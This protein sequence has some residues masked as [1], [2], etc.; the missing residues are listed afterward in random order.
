MG[1][2]LQ[3]TIETIKDTVLTPGQGQSTDYSPGEL[4]TLVAGT[5]LDVLATDDSQWRGTKKVKVTFANGLTPDGGGPAKNTWW[6]YAPGDASLWRIV[7]NNGLPSLEESEKGPIIQIPGVGPVGL[8]DPIIA[9]GHFTW[10]EATMGGSRIPQ[11]THIPG[12]I[13]LPD[14]DISYQ[15]I[16]LAQ[17]LE[18]L[19]G[20]FGPLRINSW[21]RDPSSNKAVGGVSNSRHLYGHAADVFPLQ[22]DLR[23]FQ[24]WC[25][26]N[27]YGG[28]GYTY[29]WGCHLDLRGYQ[30]RW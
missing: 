7:Y 23:A 6:A 28:C 2:Y 25:A 5:T 17:E 3:G 4:C 29:S 16:R 20:K 12:G 18:K 9:N 24:N 30:S 15:I 1:D 10:S 27:W 11:N 8:H 21:Y 26:V 22:S 14:G 19:R 13:Y